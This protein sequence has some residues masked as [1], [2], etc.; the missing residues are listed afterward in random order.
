MGEVGLLVL[1]QHKQIWATT[2]SLRG[3]EKGK[4]KFPRVGNTKAGW[5]YTNLPVGLH[6]RFL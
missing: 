1:T 3:Q 2:I 5:S 4:T 6:G